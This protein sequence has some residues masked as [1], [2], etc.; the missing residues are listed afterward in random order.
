MLHKTASINGS[1]L[2]ISFYYLVA[3]ID[4]NVLKLYL[5]IQCH[6]LVSK[7]HFTFPHDCDVR[8]H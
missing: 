2:Y 4:A 8:F 6:L 1:L 7:G 5:N 3:L